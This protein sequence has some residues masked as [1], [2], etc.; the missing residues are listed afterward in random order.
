MQTLLQASQYFANIMHCLL[1]LCNSLN[2]TKT[3]YVSL[4]YRIFLC[5]CK[6]LW[7]NRSSSNN[8][9]YQC[10]IIKITVNTAN[11]LNIYALFV[12]IS[13]VK[14]ISNTLLQN[15][16]ISNQTHCAGGICCR[17][18]N[19]VFQQSLAYPVM[20]TSTFCFTLIIH[21]LL[22]CV[23]YQ[24]RTYEEYQRFNLFCFIIMN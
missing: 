5:V 11:S 18:S 1:H 10:F 9:C 24:L 2:T 23:N 12:L 14:C 21:S 3:W 22:A 7:Y 8:D 13:Y 19:G 17:K 4:S 16:F 6:P 20:S 15:Y